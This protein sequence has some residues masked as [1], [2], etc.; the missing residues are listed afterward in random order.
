MPYDPRAN[1]A[2]FLAR[3]PFQRQGGMDAMGIANMAGGGMQ[4]MG[5][6]MPT[7]PN[8]WQRGGQTPQSRPLS[9]AM[10]QV[11]QPGPPMPPAMGG[12]PQGAPPPPPSSLPPQP[13]PFANAGLAAAVPGSSAG[14]GMTPPPTGGGM[15]SKG[16]GAMPPQM[17]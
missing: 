11:A 13:M 12:G 17:R 14:S 15:G 3:A 7:A 10:G 2:Q 16:A 8:W 9:G 4:R 5:P 1:I 6:N